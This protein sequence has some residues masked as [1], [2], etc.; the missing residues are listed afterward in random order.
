MK[1]G[2]VLSGGGARGFAHLGVLQAL[3]ELDIPVDM[4]TGTSA[5]AIAGAFYSAGHTPKETM[6]LIRSYK[7]YEWMRFLWRK[8]GFL[9]MQKIGSMFAKHL[10]DTF[11]GLN[12]PLVITATDLLK[13]ETRFFSEGPLIFP[14]CASACVPILFEPMS[15]D[16]SVYV[17]GG[18]LNNFATEPLEGKVQHIIGVHVNPIDKNISKVHFSNVMDRSMHLALRH[19]LD[20]KKKKCTIF[21]EPEACSRFGIF[22]I[23][24]A[25]QLFEAGYMAAMARKED[26][27]HFR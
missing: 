15:I 4:I 5:G 11:E 19:S 17:D 22:D 6:R 1:N 12:R 26:L 8:P 20:E 23:E 24:H 27:I 25:E 21:I 3:D 10:P 13:G 16:G 7:T 9:N 2:L 18:I 14:V